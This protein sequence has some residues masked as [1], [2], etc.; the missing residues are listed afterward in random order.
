M[1]N[2]CGGIKKEQS[3]ISYRITGELLR[4]T[5]HP[6]SGIK[7]MQNEPNYV[8]AK[9]QNPLR[10]MF[11]KLQ[12]MLQKMQRSTKKCKRNCKK[13]RTFALIY[14]PKA[15][16]SSEF[17]KKNALFSQTFIQ[18]EP[19][20]NH[21]F[22]N[23]LTRIMRLL[24]LFIRL[25]RTFTQKLK[26]MRN[27]CK[28]LKLTH[29]TPCTTKT[30]ITFYHKIPLTSEIYTQF[31]RKEKIQNK[32]NFIPIIVKLIML[33][34]RRSRSLSRHL[35]SAPGQNKPNFNHSAQRVTGHGPRVTN[36]AKQTQFH[37]FA[38][39]VTGHGPRVTNYAKRSQSH[40]E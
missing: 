39:R 11:K 21:T 3:T 18:N 36:Y 22:S 27:F 8:P 28:L 1:T 33:S 17:T 19:N 37:Q 15:N 32:P 31:W 35:G 29:L 40:T 25:M 10:D 4:H 12:N 34:R 6:I 5:T 26:K 16:F 24:Q 30:Y 20:F 7:K 13:A 14:P 2:R 38:K 23:I 9:V